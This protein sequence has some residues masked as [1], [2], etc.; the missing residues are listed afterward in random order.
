MYVQV[1]VLEQ[2]V[3]L[4]WG[5]MLAWEFIQQGNRNGVTYEKDDQLL[6]QVELNKHSE[7]LKTIVNFLG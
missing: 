1:F 4:S 7:K 5:L 3:S 2:F 6:R